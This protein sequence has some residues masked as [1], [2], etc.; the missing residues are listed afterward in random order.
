MASLNK[1]I[2]IGN[3]GRDPELK[4]TPSGV[5]VC[6]FSIATTERY[7]DQDG[8]PQEKT[9]WHNIKVWRKQAEVAAEYLKKGRQVYIEGRI[10]TQTW[11]KEGQKN[12][13]TEIVARKILMLGRKE[14]EVGPTP[15]TAGKPAKEPSEPPPEIP[16]EDDL[17]F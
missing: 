9:E 8:N 6:T 16:D 3:L 2:L 5:P 10:E 11:E 7:K 12:Y 15:T 1:A 14:E 13:R 17:P 4:Y